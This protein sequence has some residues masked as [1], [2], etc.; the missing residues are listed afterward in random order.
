MFNRKKGRMM[1]HPYA[2]LAV[3]GL[4]AVGVISI[5]EKMKCFF[6][7]KARCVS[8]MLSSMNKG[9]K[10]QQEYY[11]MGRSIYFTKRGEEYENDRKAYRKHTDNQA[12]ENRESSWDKSK[13]FRKA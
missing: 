2:T 6:G 9:E 5:S 7:D 12:K 3:L 4:A 1:R 11:S 8:N 13:A 10:A